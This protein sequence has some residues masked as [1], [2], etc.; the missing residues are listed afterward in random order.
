M[1]DICEIIMTCLGKKFLSQNFGINNHRFNALNI[2][3]IAKKYPYC[4]PVVQNKLFMYNDCE[5]LIVYA[6]IPS[7]HRDTIKFLNSGFLRYFHI[8]TK[9]LYV[10]FLA[11]FNIFVFLKFVA[12]RITSKK[13]KIAPNAKIVRTSPYLSIKAPIIGHMINPNPKIAH[14]RPK[15]FAL[16]SLSGDIS[17]KIA[18]K[19]E[20]L[21]HVI[22]LIA[23][24]RINIQYCFVINKIR[25][26]RNVPNTHRTNEVFLPI[27]SDICHSN[28]AERNAN[29]EYIVSPNVT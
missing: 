14:I 8:T 10:S 18:C 28:G 27:L 20:I 15:F 24:E 5:A 6:P 7:N 12:I 17:V 26:E 11:L 4:S 2:H 23:L 21:P 9:L 16:V 1:S 13:A 19:I 29:S 25:Y 3:A 22:P